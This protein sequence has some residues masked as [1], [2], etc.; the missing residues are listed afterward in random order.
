MSG[1]SGL[2]VIELLLLLIDSQYRG[3][4]QNLDVSINSDYSV[5]SCLRYVAKE[6][7]PLTPEQGRGEK[8]LLYQ[9]DISDSLLDMQA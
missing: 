5:A 8:A 4:G 9:D 3:S 1:Q 2:N 7:T 6:N